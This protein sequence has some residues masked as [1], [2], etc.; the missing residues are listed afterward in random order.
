MTRGEILA[1]TAAWEPA[2][3]L[4]DTGADRIVFSGDKFAL[5][6]LQ[7]F[8]TNERLGGVGGV[9]DAVIIETQIRLTRDGAGKVV[10]NFLI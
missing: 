7:P 4:V 1:G 6:N 3:F 2:L 5:L 9:A 8:A 10:F